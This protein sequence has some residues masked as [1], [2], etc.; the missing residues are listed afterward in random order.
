MSYKQ[1]EKAEHGEAGSKKGCFTEI[2]FKVPLAEAQELS[3]WTD[4]RGF[5]LNANDED[6]IS[7]ANDPTTPYNH[8]PYAIKFMAEPGEFV[9]NLNLK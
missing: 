6:D 4:T 9:N 5:P 8:N 7:N 3:L 2:V 1:K